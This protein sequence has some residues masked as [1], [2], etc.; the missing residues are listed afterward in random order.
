VRIFTAEREK[1]LLVPRSALFR[2]AGN[3]WQVFAVRGG[4]A[5]LQT[6]EIGLMNDEQAE[7]RK[8]LADREL[9]VLAPESSLSD[10][11][12]VDASGK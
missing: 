10:G 11:A 8:G 4:I 9:V 6:V 1:A 7:V 12:K 5:R 2:A 3:S